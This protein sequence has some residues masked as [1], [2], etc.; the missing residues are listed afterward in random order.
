[1]YVREK[2][3]DVLSM[4]HDIWNYFIHD[5]TSRPRIDPNKI[6]LFVQLYHHSD[7]RNVS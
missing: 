1:M 6:D 5:N 7:F 3:T 2:K 4:A